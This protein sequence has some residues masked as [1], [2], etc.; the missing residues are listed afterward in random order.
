MPVFPSFFYLLSVL[1]N[2]SPCHI[3]FL[4][5][6][7]VNMCLLRLDVDSAIPIYFIK[8]TIKAVSHFYNSSI[9]WKN[10]EPLLI[11]KC[12]K[13]IGTVLITEKRMSARHDNLDQFCFTWD[14]LQNA[15]PWLL[16][17]IS[18][19]IWPL[20]C[21]SQSFFSAAASHLLSAFFCCFFAR[22]LLK[23]LVFVIIWMNNWYTV[24]CC[25]STY[26]ACS[27][28]NICNINRSWHKQNAGILLA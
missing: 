27:L 12:S 28:I 14:L 11:S 6:S 20:F 3:L 24:S 10:F 23:Y 26:Y 22:F 18:V 25:M 7:A 4:I 1:A 21:P 17:L 13:K 9:L 2:C 8:P 16:P 5:F 19:L 15:I